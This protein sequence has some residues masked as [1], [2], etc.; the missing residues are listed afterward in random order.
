MGKETFLSTKQGQ[1]CTWQFLD[2]A[3]LE[4]YFPSSE[5]AQQAAAEGSF[6]WYL[7]T[8]LRGRG[9]GMKNEHPVS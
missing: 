3:T 4:W 5:F 1:N 9:K 6:S 7:E 2:S 8:G